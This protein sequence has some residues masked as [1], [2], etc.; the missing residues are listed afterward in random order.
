[1]YQSL[2]TKFMDSM[3]ERPNTDHL[4]QIKTIG[5]G[6]LKY[7]DVH[8]GMSH[9][10]PHNEIREFLRLRV[11][12]IDYHRSRQGVWSPVLRQIA[13]GKPDDELSLT[14]NMDVFK[15]YWLA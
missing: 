4:I 15:H 8:V 7:A 14:H 1:M 2:A 12:E 11:Y 9:E 13:K 5:L 10:S 3:I 6:S